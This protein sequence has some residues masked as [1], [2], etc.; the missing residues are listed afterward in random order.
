LWPSILFL[1]YK[2]RFQTAGAGRL[3]ALGPIWWNRSNRLK[4]GWLRN[5]NMAANIYRFV[6]SYDGR[7]FL[8]LPH[9]TFEH[10]CHAWWFFDRPSDL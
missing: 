4:T 1:E 9:V 6:S 10:W 3:E 5:N 8:L 2:K 7:R